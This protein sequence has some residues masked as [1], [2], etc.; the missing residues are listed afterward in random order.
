MIVWFNVKHFMACLVHV[1]AMRMPFPGLFGRCDTTPASLLPN[2]LENR[3]ALRGKYLRGKQ[4]APH[5]KE[6]AAL[7]GF[8]PGI[9]VYSRRRMVT[10]ARLRQPMTRNRL[11]QTPRARM[12]TVSA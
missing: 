9:A 4:M 8:G 1:N 10:G 7:A 3:P 11:L 6:F 2:V 5:R 12:Q